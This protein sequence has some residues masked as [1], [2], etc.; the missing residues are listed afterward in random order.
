[1][2]LLAKKSKSNMPKLYEKRLKNCCSSKT[3]R[4][5]RAGK[6]AIKVPMH[7]KINP[8][9]FDQMDIYKHC[10]REYV[11]YRNFLS[12]E[13]YLKDTMKQCNSENVSPSRLNCKSNYLARRSGI[14]EV[15]HECR[16]C[17]KNKNVLR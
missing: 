10:S 4:E 8:P 1:M 9:S 5:M 7:L 6:V 11:K 13:N 2:Y 3:N 15:Q 14:Q 16:C 12:N 17:Q